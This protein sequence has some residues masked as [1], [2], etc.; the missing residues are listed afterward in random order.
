MH[1]FTWDPSIITEPEA[2]LR[3]RGVWYANHKYGN[4]PPLMFFCWG[5]PQTNE[6]LGNVS[7]DFVELSLDPLQFWNIDLY[8]QWHNCFCVFVK[9]YTLGKLAP[10]YGHYT[11]PSNLK[12]NILFPWK[13]ILK[14]NKA[15]IVLLS[16]LVK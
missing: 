15:S 3:T 11:L 13:E 1:P 12:F 16:L 14:R 9:S 7:D 6:R 5:I 2:I 10:S 4:F 8:R